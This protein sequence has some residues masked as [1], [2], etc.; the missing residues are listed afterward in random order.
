MMGLGRGRAG[1]EG[2]E[3]SMPEGKSSGHQ[4]RIG[5]VT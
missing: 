2:S 1:E 4:E 3:A 5:D